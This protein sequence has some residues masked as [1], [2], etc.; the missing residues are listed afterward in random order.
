MNIEQQYP[1]SISEASATDMFFKF[2]SFTISEFIKQNGSVTI[3][4]L[5]IENGLKFRT[6][7]ASLVKGK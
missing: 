5:L 6:I 7:S 4:N 1:L 3:K 2:H